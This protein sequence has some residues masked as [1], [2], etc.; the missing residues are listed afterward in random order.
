MLSVLLEVKIIIWFDILFE[1]IW[2]IENRGLSGGILIFIWFYFYGNYFI[3]KLVILGWFKLII[4]IE[5]IE[6]FLGD[7]YV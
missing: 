1:S 5:V 7:L 4:F 2:K 6:F 3:F